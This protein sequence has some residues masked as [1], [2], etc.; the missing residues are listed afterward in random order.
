MLFFFQSFDTLDC[1]SK[2]R[3]SISIDFNSNSGTK[4][5]KKIEKRTDYKKTTSNA[6]ILWMWLCV[7]CTHFI[8]FYVLVRFFNIQNT[9]FWLHSS[10]ISLLRIFIKCKQRDSSLSRRNNC[11]TRKRREWIYRDQKVI[12]DLRTN[13]MPSQIELYSNFLMSITLLT[14]VGKCIQL[15]QLHSFLQIKTHESGGFRSGK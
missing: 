10:S 5:E 7:R 15:R 11:I 13:E 9:T 14:I 8:L 6:I 4:I 1:V 2:M 12:A 3:L